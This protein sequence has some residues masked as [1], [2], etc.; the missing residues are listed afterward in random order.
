LFAQGSPIVLSRR[1]A[2]ILIF[3]WEL[4][5][6]IYRINGGDASTVGFFPMGRVFCLKSISAL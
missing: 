1:T 4:V 6:D 3:V 2:Q 5:R